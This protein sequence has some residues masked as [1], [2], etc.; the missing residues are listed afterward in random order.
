MMMG[1]WF[2]ASAYGQYGAGII[3]AG[4]A[5]SNGSENL[6]AIQKMELYTNGYQTIG[7]IAIVAG[8][9]LI[10]LSPMILKLMKDKTTIA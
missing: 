5:S 6:N 8:V 9:I 3:G 2:L 7:Y 1:S 10:V 4:M